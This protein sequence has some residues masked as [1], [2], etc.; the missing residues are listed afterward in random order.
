MKYIVMECHFS[1][2]V[3]L[4]E[5]GKFVKAA[6]RS[7]QVG[8]TVYDP[9]LVGDYRYR[10]YPPALRIIGRVIGI[11][12]IIL[13]VF[14]CVRYCSSG[15]TADPAVTTDP[16]ITELHA[17]SI[18]LAHAGVTE[19]SAVFESIELDEENGVK[20]Y[21]LEFAVDGTE[22]EYEINA[23]TGQILKFKSE[24]TD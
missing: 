9:V 15:K 22:Y 4:D 8:Q 3:L 14:L 11:L 1:Y 19:D 23:L 18:A 7:Y 12:V 13:T 21:E 20:V 2:A 16:M 24:S 5:D 10:H 6:N 17:K